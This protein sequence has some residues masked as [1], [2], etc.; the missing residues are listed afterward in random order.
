MYRE[1]PPTK[2]AQFAERV[3]MVKGRLDNK[4]STATGYARLVWEKDVVCPPRL[5]WVP[6][7]RKQLE[8]DGDYPGVFE[9]LILNHLRKQ[10]AR[11][12]GRSRGLRERS[13][14]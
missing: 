11:S 8:R 6:P 9:N 13:L 2:V 10:T 12:R 7:C 1:R 4:V 5:M 3:P 14:I